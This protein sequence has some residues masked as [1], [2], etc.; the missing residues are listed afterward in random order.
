MN[1][2]IQKEKKEG[3]NGHSKKIQT[4]KLYDDPVAS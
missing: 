3:R 4:P 2:T 1:D